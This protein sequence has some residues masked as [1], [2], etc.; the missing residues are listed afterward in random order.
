LDKIIL[1]KVKKYVGEIF[2]QKFSDEIHYHN[3]TH[4]TEVVKVIEEISSAMGIDEQNRELLLIAGWF[5]DI[6]YT[7]CYDAHED[8]GIEIA[9]NFLKKNDYPEEKTEKVISL[10][11]VTRLP[12]NP[13]NILEEIICDADLHHLGTIEFSKKEK[14]FREEIET[15]KGCKVTDKVW[16]ENNLAFLTQHEFYTTYAKEKFGYQK[17]INLT[18]IQKKLNEL[19]PN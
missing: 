17:K 19:Q 8:T 1:S 3:F 10:I 18:N 9:R 13:Q 7:E 5:H 12:R 16:L 15:R 2:R 4:T 6:G 14:L 11:N